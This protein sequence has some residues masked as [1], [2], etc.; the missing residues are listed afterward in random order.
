[1]EAPAELAEGIVPVEADA[2]LPRKRPVQTGG[3]VQ[4]QPGVGLA[5]FGP[6]KLQRLVQLVQHLHGIVQPEQT[7]I[8]QAVVALFLVERF[9]QGF[10]LSHRELP[11]STS[12]SSTLPCTD[13]PTEIF[14]GAAC[15]LRKASVR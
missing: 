4:G 2:V 7:A 6:G 8:A 5:Q 14:G 15:I 9:Q 1:M 10:Q 12:R 13:T 11:V 3:P